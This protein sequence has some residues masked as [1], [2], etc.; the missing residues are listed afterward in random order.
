MC[1]RGDGPRRRVRVT[2]GVTLIVAVNVTVSVLVTKRSVF[3]TH[4]EFGGAHPRASD[5]FGPD[6]IRADGESP[7]CASKIAQRQTGVEQ[8]AENH[9]ASGA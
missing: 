6:V 3:A 8:R 1:L 2:M 5:S 4:M 9:V 7:Q